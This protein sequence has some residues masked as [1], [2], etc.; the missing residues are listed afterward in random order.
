M[1][2][3]SLASI[4]QTKPSKLTATTLFNDAVADNS[5]ALKLASGIFTI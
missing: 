3:S 5:L 2:P 1:I 4:L